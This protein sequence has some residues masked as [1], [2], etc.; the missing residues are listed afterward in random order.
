MR[1]TL[2]LTRHGE[3]E[4]N[5][6][7]KMQGHKNSPLTALGELQAAWLGESLRD[8]QIDVIYSSSSQRTIETAEIICAHRDIQFIKTDNLREI[9]M[10]LWEGEL[11]SD[12]QQNDPEQ[13][14]NFWNRPHMYNPINGGESFYDLQAR[15]IPFV[16]RLIEEYK[17]KT[18]LLV[19]H[20]AT[21]K[22]LMNYFDKNSLE[23]LWDLPFIQSTSLSKVVIDN[24]YTKI[25]LYG[26]TSHYQDI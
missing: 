4:W 21:L 3:T 23:R 11:T 9:Y 14:H 15:V 5:V 16:Q 22:V 26:D 25:E 6:V 17:G 18:L 7:K 2:Y 12:I 24:T 10:G 19:T 1:T 20:A 13:F 8:T